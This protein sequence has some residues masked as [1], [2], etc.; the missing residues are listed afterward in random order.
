MRRPKGAPE[1]I[2]PGREIF[3]VD[4]SGVDVKWSLRA[5]HWAIAL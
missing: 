4:R 2:T 5:A 3:D 1:D